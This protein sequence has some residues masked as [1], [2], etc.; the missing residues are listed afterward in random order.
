VHYGFGPGGH[1][2]IDQQ[3][4]TVDESTAQVVHFVI[5]ATPD[6]AEDL[7]IDQLRAIGYDITFNRRLR[8]PRIISGSSY[9][10]PVAGTV[11]TT[12]IMPS[13][14]HCPVQVKVARGTRLSWG[15]QG[16][17]GRFGRV[18]FSSRL[19][20]RWPGRVAPGVTPSQLNSC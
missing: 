11:A 9:Q 20:F 5:R 18:L 10:S 2:L 4:R 16:R 7:A 15:S 8:S 19:Q 1:G 13:T 12:P 6:K 3:T 14:H 17:S